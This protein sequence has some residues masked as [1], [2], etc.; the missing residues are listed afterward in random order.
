M[1]LQALSSSIA[2]HGQIRAR[3]RDGELS[4]FPQSGPKA[5][6]LTSCTTCPCS[7]PF[8]NE[9]RHTRRIRRRILGPQEFYGAFPGMQHLG[10]RSESS[11][12]Q[13]FQMFGHALGVGSLTGWDGRVL[14][15]PRRNSKFRVPSQTTPWA[16]YELRFRACTCSSMQI[17]KP[18]SHRTGS[19]C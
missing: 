1:D 4:P 6:A 16:D 3:P 19:I 5:P 18:L 17:L 8:P 12:S 2:D 11:F 15:R 9:S 10:M 13:P 14:G 7:T